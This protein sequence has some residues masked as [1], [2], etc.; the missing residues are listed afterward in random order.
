MDIYDYL[1]AAVQFG[2]IYLVIY[3]LWFVG[4]RRDR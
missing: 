3:A 2:V 1:S 4:W